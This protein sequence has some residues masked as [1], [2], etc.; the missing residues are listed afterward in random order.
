MLGA[1]EHLRIQSVPPLSLAFGPGYAPVILYACEGA[2]FVGAMC[3]LE[4]PPVTR[5]V[6]RHAKSQALAPGCR[7]PLAHYVA[8]RS[9][10]DGVPGLMLRTPRVEPV[11][12]IGQGDKQPCSGVFVTFDQRVRLPIEER[13]LRA[14]ILVPELGG[15]TI[16]RILEVVVGRSLLIHVARIPIAVFGHTLRAPVRPNAELGVTIPFRSLVLEQRIPVRLV[17]SIAVKT[18]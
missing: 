7:G 10:I 4:P 16:V 1:V 2:V 8:M 13:P 15:R 17:R 9:V 11:V 3:G 12:V 5:L 14:Q 6:H 18:G